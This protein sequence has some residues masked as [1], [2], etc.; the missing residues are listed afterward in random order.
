M[1]NKAV[2]L[3]VKVISIGLWLGLISLFTGCPAKPHND[4]GFLQ[5]VYGQRISWKDKYPVTVYIH[6][7]VPKS[8]RPAIYRAAATWESIIGRKVFDIS[9]DSS[10]LSS[11]PTRDGKNGIYFLSN[12]ESDKLSEQGRTS[13]LWAGDEIQEADIRINH[14][15]YSFYEQTPDQLV[16]SIS[17]TYK[18]YQRSDGVNNTSSGVSYSFEALMLHEMGHFLG[19]KHRE[20]SGKDQGTVMATKLAAF[21]NRVVPAESDREAVKCEY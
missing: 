18:A 16:S 11:E 9:E 17:E 6:S 1:E 8:L 13:V 14:Y 7:S 5:D 21:N 20:S 10:K 4:C 2:R 12:W 3:F 15:S 19:L